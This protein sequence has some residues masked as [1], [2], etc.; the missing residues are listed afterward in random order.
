MEVK[1]VFVEVEQA[2]KQPAIAETLIPTSVTIFGNCVVRKDGENNQAFIN[3]YEVNL[4]VRRY[5]L[6]LL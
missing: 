6:E 2:Q 4:C 1:K 3:E 5:F